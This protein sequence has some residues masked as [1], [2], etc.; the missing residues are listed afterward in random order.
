VLLNLVSIMRG[1]VHA[2]WN[3]VG[4]PSLNTTMTVANAFWGTGV[5]IVEVFDPL[6]TYGTV[7][8]GPTYVLKPG[9]GL[10]VHAPTDSVWTVNW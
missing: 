10:W 6:Q 3:M 4:Y 8:V 9:E 2:G 7:A 1:A 5:D